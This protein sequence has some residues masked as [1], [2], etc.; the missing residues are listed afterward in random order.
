MFVLAQPGGVM[1]IHLDR[2]GFYQFIP[3]S[4]RQQLLLKIL[5]HASYRNAKVLFPV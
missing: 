4:E 2:V 1:D 5:G 3:Q